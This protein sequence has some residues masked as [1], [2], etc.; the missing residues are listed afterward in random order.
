MMRRA[1]RPLAFARVWA[2]PSR[3]LDGTP[4]PTARISEEISRSIRSNSDSVAPT[5]APVSARCPSQMRSEALGESIA[6][7]GS[8]SELRVGPKSEAD[9][10]IGRS[11]DE[12]VSAAIRRVEGD[13]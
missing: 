3:T 8:V 9:G 10:L 5:L 2:P 4:Q 13:T 11:R 6:V 1:A 7:L 12:A